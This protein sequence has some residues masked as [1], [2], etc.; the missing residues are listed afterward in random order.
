[1]GRAASVAWMLMPQGRLPSNQLG[2]GTSLTLPPS[3]QHRS[4]WTEG[5]RREATPR[6]PQRKTG[7]V[8]SPRYAL[9]REMGQGWL[10]P[11]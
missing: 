9:E 1:M 3:L 2:F 7:R 6:T 10:W 5:G 11:V 4:S 8:T